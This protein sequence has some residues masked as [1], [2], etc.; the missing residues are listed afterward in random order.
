[1]SYRLAIDIGAS[2]GRHILVH[3]EDG[4]VVLE[5]LY[6]FTTPLFEKDGHFFWDVEALFREVVAGLKA[7]A[8]KGRIPERIGIDTFGVDYA[9]LDG[10]DRLLSPIVSYRDERTLVAKKEFL[11][12]ETVFKETG[13]QPQSFDS[14]YQLYCDKKS[15]LLAKAKT[16]MFLP[17]YLAYR[18]SGVKQN[19]RSILSTSALYD[20]GRNAYSSLILSSLGLKEEFFPP[21]LEAGSKIGPLRGDVAKEI[22]YQADVYAALEHDTASAFYGSNAKANDVL[23]SSG[24]WSL[25]GCVLKTPI[26]SQAVYESGFTNELSHQGEVRFLKNVTGM[27]MV[28]RLLKECPQ[29]HGVIEAVE[30]ARYSTYSGV[31]DATDPSLLNPKDMKASLLALLKKSQAPAPKNDEDIF[32]SVF[33]SL[34]VCYANA[35][36]EMERLTGRQFT[37]IL[38]FGGGSKNELLNELTSKET[39]LPVYRGPVEATALGNIRSIS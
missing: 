5:E 39:R 2:S 36:K 37:A 35:V 17:S 18:L 13:I 14:V 25:I 23:I 27:W 1:M 7:A 32:Y 11:T 30:Q 15:G 38:I 9:L 4:H 34:A 33:H 12:P 22:G 28:N 20:G 10:D 16:L 3:E 31:F 24:T 21:I 26:V 8:Q 19:E 29:Y 6:R